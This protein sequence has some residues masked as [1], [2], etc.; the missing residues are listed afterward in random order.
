M[1]TRK[2]MLKLD[3]DRVEQLNEAMRVY[4]QAVARAKAAAEDLGLAHSDLIAVLYPNGPKTRGVDTW[5]IGYGYQLKVEFPMNFTLDKTA[6]EPAKKMV[7]ELPMIE[8]TGEVPSLDGIIKYKPEFNET[9]YRSA[10]ESVKDVCRKLNLFG[11][12][13]GKAKIE[14]KEPGQSKA[15]PKAKAKADDLP[16]EAF[17]E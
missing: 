17:E 3:E 15:A 10:P 16:D 12:S 4:H 9:A 2:P 8:E 5:D 1:A 14:V 13:W 6:I 11:W 7:S